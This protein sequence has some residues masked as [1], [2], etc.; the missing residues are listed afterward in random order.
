MEPTVRY[1]GER[2][3]YSV[4]VYEYTRRGE[5]RFS[6]RIVNLTTGNSEETPGWS[7]YGTALMVAQQEADE[8]KI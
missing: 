6:A 5:T 1:A 8:A 3:G 4:K 2:N 7:T